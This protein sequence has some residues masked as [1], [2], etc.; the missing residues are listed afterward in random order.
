MERTTI[1]KVIRKEG[2]KGFFKRWGDGIKKIP[3]DQLLKS[4]ILGITG[5]I[6]GTIAACLI[7]IL[8]MDNLWPI[9]LIL[10]FNVIIQ[11]SQL[12]GKWQ[13]LK[14]MQA[15]KDQFQSV[16]DFLNDVN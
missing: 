15:M 2:L 5:S 3:P 8:V 11:G 13:Q 16:Q 9:A 14:Q 4:E 7:F 10:G 1:S 6:L 12:I